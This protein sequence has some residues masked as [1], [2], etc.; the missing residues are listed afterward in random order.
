MKLKLLRMDEFIQKKKIQ[1][2]KDSKHYAGNNREDFNKEGIFSQEIFGR[3]GSVNRKKTFG[4]IDLQG[5]FIH[6]E[7]FKI[8]TSINTDLTKLIL[9]SEYY[10]IDEKGNLI[11]DPEK[12]ST[13]VSFFVENFDKIDFNNLKTN[14]PKHIQYVLKYKKDLLINK[15]LILPAGIRDVQ[16]SSTGQNFILNSEV[17]ML[18]TRLINQTNMLSNVGLIDDQIHLSLTKNIQSTLNEINAWIK[19]KIKGK[20]GIIR[21]GLLK[22]VVDYCARLVIVPDTK[23]K[24]GFVGIPW[25]ICLKLFEP[26]F[27]HYILKEDPSDMIKSLIQKELGLEDIDINDIKHFNNKINESPFEISEMTKR[28][29]IKVAKIITDDKVVITKRDPVNF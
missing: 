13:G 16:I 14:K 10:L 5:T 3:L 21:G 25:H 26:M 4:Y 19:N 23:I 17:N 1:Q 7:G 20:Y 8:L 2:V 18:Y 27:I 6:P 22:K 11:K 15:Y 29:L 24:F 9:G 28:E 12:G